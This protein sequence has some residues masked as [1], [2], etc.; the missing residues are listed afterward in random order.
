MNKSHCSARLLQPNI[1]LVVSDLDGTLLNPQHQLTS[2][3][4]QA[5]EALESYG[6]QFMIATGR[7][8]QDVALIAQQIQT[9]MCL[10][11]SNG[12]RVH[13]DCGELVYENHIPS[14]LVKTVLDLSTGFN[15]HRNIYK[16]ALW[17]VEEPHEALLAIHDSGFGYHLCDFTNIGLESIDKIYFTAEHSAL[18]ALEAHLKAHLAGQLYITFTSPEYLEVMNLGV[19]KGQALQGLLDKQGLVPEQVMALG[20]GMNDKEMLALVGHKVVMQNASDRVKA[21][22]PDSPVAKS[23]AENGVADYLKRSVLNHL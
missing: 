4:C 2:E 21:L 12:A 15:V 8:Y 11:T 22:F 19:S 5:I 10:I 9:P 3:T 18:L 7:H 16:Q 1:K 17:L 14:K 20:D 6:V 13:N 23:N